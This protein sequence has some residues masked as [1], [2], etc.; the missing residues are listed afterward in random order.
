MQN[1]DVFSTKSD[2]VYTQLKD[3]ILKGVLKQGESI[4]ISRIAEEYSISAIPVREA[5]KRLE[6]EGLVE[7]IPHKGAQ[8][9]TL[10]NDRIKEVISIR[11]VLEGYAARTALPYMDEEK[12][13]ILKKMAEKMREHALAGDSEKFG[14][15]NKEFH[16]FLYKQSPFPMLYDMIFNLWDGGN[17]SKAIFAFNPERMKDSINE[18]IEIIAAIEKQDEEKTEILVRMHKERIGKLLLEISKFWFA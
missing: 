14:A 9:V 16:R 2:Y 10:N 18:H 5:L 6:T 13:G 3:K 11:A 8:V 15:E 7:I 4:T 12:I 1:A 17:W